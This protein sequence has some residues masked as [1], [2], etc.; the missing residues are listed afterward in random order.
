[1]KKIIILLLLLHSPLVFSGDTILSLRT[2]F[3]AL[4]KDFMFISSGRTD[5][6]SQNFRQIESLWQSKKVTLKDKDWGE[7]KTVEINELNFNEG[8]DAQHFLIFHN[9]K[10]V[11]ADVKG[12]Y[13]YQSGC[14][15]EI[16][17]ILNLGKWPFEKIDDFYLGIA[18]EI[19]SKYG[20]PK[21]IQANTDFF[22]QLS[23]DDKKYIRTE[24]FHP[25]ELKWENIN[26]KKII[27]VE[28]EPGTGDYAYEL[29]IFDKKL[30]KYKILKSKRVLD[31]RC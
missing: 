24:Y 9:K 7:L 18:I 3:H 20:L 14:A 15:N 2:I 17:P 1:M 22:S 31:G 25:L 10:I 8:A 5:N 29:I 11:P 13:L 16:V 6:H 21:I 19:N 27:L 12:A 4:D 23:E 28:Y 30:K 26:D